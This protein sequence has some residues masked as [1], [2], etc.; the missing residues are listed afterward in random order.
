MVRGNCNDLE[1]QPM[2]K[3]HSLHHMSVP[4]ARLNALTEIL[5]LDGVSIEW[6]K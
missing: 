3:N 6:N 1:D 5:A 2:G 4:Y